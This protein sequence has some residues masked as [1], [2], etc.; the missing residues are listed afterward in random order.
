MWMFDQYD[1]LIVC[2]FRNIYF[3][4]DQLWE[5]VWNILMFSSNIFD[6]HP[7]DHEIGECI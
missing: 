4:D 7:E 2:I 6:G 1:I 5:F 3:I